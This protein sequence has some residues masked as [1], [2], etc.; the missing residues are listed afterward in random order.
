MGYFDTSLA[1]EANNA[2]VL[3]HEAVSL[4]AMGHREDAIQ[5]LKQAMGLY[6]SPPGS[7]RKL[8]EKCGRGS[9]ACDVGS[10]SPKDDGGGFWPG[11]TRILWRNARK[12]WSAGSSGGGD[13]S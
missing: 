9:L 8:L 10:L 5:A 11:L 7:W 6:K 1:V 13:I 12:G 4:K 2:G 3:Y